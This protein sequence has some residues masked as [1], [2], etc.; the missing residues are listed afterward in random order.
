MS[1]LAE[2]DRKFATL[3][4]IS[5]KFTVTA[6]SF[7]L[8]TWCIARLFD[9]SEFMISKVDLI[10]N[11]E[12]MYWY[13]LT[14]FKFVPITLGLIAATVLQLKSPYKISGLLLGAIALFGWVG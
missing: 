4:I 3:L 13:S 7:Y 5:I 8:L 6:F 10:S 9:R 11:I 1:Q 2:I 12:I 14:I